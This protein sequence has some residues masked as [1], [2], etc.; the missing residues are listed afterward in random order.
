MLDPEIDRAGPPEI[1]IPAQQLNFFKLLS[2]QLSGSIRGTVIHNDGVEVAKALF[3]HAVEE[4]L[5]E[6]FSIENG[7]NYVNLTGHQ[8]R[9]LR[10]DLS[11]APS[12]VQSRGL[13]NSFLLY[14]IA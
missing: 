2:N 14:N 1:A 6:C 4:A 5:S 9:A 7:N 10:V 8:S 11:S 13:P 3:P 12:G